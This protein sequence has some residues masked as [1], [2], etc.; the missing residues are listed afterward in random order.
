MDRFRKVAEDDIQ[1]RIAA[2][3]SEEARTL[4]ADHPDLCLA[5]LNGSP[6]K[7]VGYFAFL[8]ADIQNK[9]TELTA[10]IIESGSSRPQDWLITDKDANAEM[11]Q[12]WRKVQSKGIDISTVGKPPVTVSDERSTCIAMG[13]FM[14]NVARLPPA[15]AGG[16]M[17]YLAR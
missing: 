7:G 13:E 12:L 1:V 3:E 16:L 15:A 11:D 2:I 4:A 5:M 9:G 17:R 8:P 10:A 6:Q 14:A